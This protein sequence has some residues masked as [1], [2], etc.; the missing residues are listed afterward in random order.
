GSVFKIM[1]AAAGF[2]ADVIHEGE[3][4]YCPG[5]ATH[6]GNRFAC[7]KAG[8][9]GHISLHDA[10]VHSCNVFFYEVGDRLGID[11]IAQ[12]ATAMG[13]GRRT[14]IDLPNEDAG[15]I[16]SREWKES[17]FSAP[18]YPSETISVSI[19]Q[20]AVSVTPLQLTWAV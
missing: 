1:M 20:G 6:Y 18:W 13:L 2:A 16:P 17:A 12:F 19:G 9:H 10:L 11:R 5:Y 3:S 8:G 7:W 15:L 4:V 14:G